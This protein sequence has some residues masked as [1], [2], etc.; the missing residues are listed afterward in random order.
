MLVVLLELISEHQELDMPSLSGKKKVST[1]M[2]PR[3]F[4]ELVADVNSYDV[5]RNPLQR[6]WK[7]GSGEDE[8]S[9]AS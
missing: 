2:Y 4:G 1:N 8:Y 9:P 5:S 3:I 6:A 7:T